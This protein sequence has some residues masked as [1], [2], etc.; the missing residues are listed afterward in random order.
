M[1]LGLQFANQES[2]SPTRM[3]S[4]SLF[5]G[6]G[7][8]IALLPQSSEVKIALCTESG[9][10]FVENVLYVRSADHTTWYP[11]FAKHLHDLDTDA[12][13]GLLADIWRANQ[14]QFKV[15]KFH[16]INQIKGS[17]KAAGSPDPAQV[18]LNSTSY[19]DFSTGGTASDYTNFWTN[20]GVR[21]DLSKKFS[22]S[23]KMQLSHDADLVFRFG[24]GAFQA[25]NAIS[26]ANM[27]WVEG[28][29]GSGDKI[30]AGVSN[31]LAVTTQASTQPMLP[32]PNVSVGHRLD[33]IPAT[34][35]V[36][37]TQGGGGGV[38]INTNVPSS[39]FIP[40]ENTIKGGIQSTNTT[41]KSLFIWL[42]E[43]TYEIGSGESWL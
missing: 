22:L 13:G 11:V 19:M 43:L 16:D 38:E 27:V 6:T 41:A 30:V 36:Y 24:A 28:C 10:G 5:W 14:H 8:E 32:N 23:F 37:S 1:S 40:T 21:I 20:E 26:P 34:K 17:S 35:V 39:S 33:F 7:D 4:K 31:G 2:L 15:F 18:N 29:D 25:Q 3:D 9:S 42:A 12:T